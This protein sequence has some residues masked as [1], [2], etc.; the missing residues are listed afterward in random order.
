[1]FDVPL[2]LLTVRL[3]EPRVAELATVNTTPNWVGLINPTVP[4][5]TPVPETETVFV[6]AKFVPV[7]TAVKTVLGTPLAG[8]IDASVGAT[9]GVSESVTG[10]INGE[11]VADAEVI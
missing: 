5:V 8:F 9:I 6:G 2:P 1:M 11:F 4:T 3:R 10:M 7:M